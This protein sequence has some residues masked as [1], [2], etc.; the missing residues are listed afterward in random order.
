MIVPK[1]VEE[2]VAEFLGSFAGYLDFFVFRSISFF[3]LWLLT[4]AVKI[5]SYYRSL[6]TEEVLNS[7]SVKGT[8]A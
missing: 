6:L 1:N 4:L 7:K 3:V 8:E 5:C 2:D